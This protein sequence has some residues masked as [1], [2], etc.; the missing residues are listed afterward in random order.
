MERPTLSLDIESTTEVFGLPA[1]LRPGLDPAISAITDVA[2]A[3]DTK[4]GTTRK[5]LLTVADDAVAGWTGSETY[6]TSGRT[7]RYQPVAVDETSKALVCVDETQLLKLLPVVIR[8]VV[9]NNHIDLL[10]T[11]NGGVF[12]LPFIAERA[13][14][15]LGDATLAGLLSLAADPSVY[16]KYAPIPGHAGGYRAAFDGDISHLD[17]QAPCKPYADK[18]GIKHSLKPVAIHAGLSPIVVDQEKMHLLSSAKRWAYA[19]SDAEVT[20]DLTH[21]FWLELAL[22]GHIDAVPA[23]A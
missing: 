18:H 3:Y 5:L 6:L 19:L 4:E 22:N 2:L 12:D 7:D 9:R 11:W 8:E 17:L 20:L 10:S 14:R 1:E 16:V 23:A 13:G 21:K 15:M